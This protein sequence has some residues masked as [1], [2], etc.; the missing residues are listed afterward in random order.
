MH[1]SHDVVVRLL[2]RVELSGLGPSAPVMTDAV[3]E[4]VALREEVTSLREA[5]S[6]S[7][8]DLARYEKLF[9]AA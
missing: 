3:K 8:A 6:S 1:A 5:L 2:E 4:I 7:R 9:G